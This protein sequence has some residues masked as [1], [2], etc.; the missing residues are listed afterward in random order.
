MN[1]AHIP[2]LEKVKLDIARERVNRFSSKRHLFEL[3]H[4][5]DLLEA[6]RRMPH[7][8]EHADMILEH[9]MLLLEERIKTLA[10]LITAETNLKLLNLTR[11]ELAGVEEREID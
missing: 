11:V 4:K 7:L 6:G 9:Q 3:S 1:L 2:K 10:E 8:A 5:L